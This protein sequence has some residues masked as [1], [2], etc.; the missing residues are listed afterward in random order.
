MLLDVGHSS[1][2]EI[3]E[4]SS[5]GKLLLVQAALAMLS[6]ESLRTAA[7]APASVPSA[8]F[9]KNMMAAMM[10]PHTMIPSIL[11]LLVFV[12]VGNSVIAQS[13]GRAQ[14]KVIILSMLRIVALGV[15]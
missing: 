11:P 12:L 5:S 14:E 7:K 4:C 13:G 2:L 6:S 3:D 9:R 1:S 10:A 15:S 8:W